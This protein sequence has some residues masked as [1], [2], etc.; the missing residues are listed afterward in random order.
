MKKALLA[1]I[2]VVLAATVGT[3]IAL[4]GGT[5]EVATVD[6]HPVTRDELIFHMRRLAPAVRNEIGD[7][8]DRAALIGRLRERALA[9]A[10]KDKVLLLLAEEQGLVD[11]VDHEDFLAEVRAENERRATS[12]R[13][14]EVV[15]GVTEFSPEEYYTKR[16]T[17]LTTALRKTWSVTDAEVRAEFDADRASWSANATTYAYTK[18]VVPMPAGA[19]ADFPAGLRSRV[20]AGG[21]LA[22]VAAAEPGARLTSAT[23]AGGRSSGVN[24]HDQDLLA[25][26]TGLSPGQVSAPIPGP[27]QITYYALDGRKVDADAAF[28]K[29]AARIRQSL[30]GEKFDRYV[31]DRLA[32][33]DIEVDTEALADI[34][35]EDVA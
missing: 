25:V 2:A 7:A 16:L 18:L 17:D 33:S 12:G 8:P 13:R 35:P 19:P 27:G 28:A 14:G 24:A 1:G 26:L 31:G 22:K 23:Y 34:N 29:Y 10:E 30:M 15:Y 11:S 3:G 32:G 4:G 21:G 9:E 6:G 5:D 20:T